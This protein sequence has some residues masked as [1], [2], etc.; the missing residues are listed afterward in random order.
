MLAVTWRPPLHFG[1]PALRY[2]LQVLRPLHGGDSAA[3]MLQELRLAEECGQQLRSWESLSDQLQALSFTLSD[4]VP[5]REYVFR[6]RAWSEF[7]WSEF[8]A[9]S[10]GF[11][12]K[13]RL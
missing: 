13:R 7:G 12:T 5:A 2:E 6:V 9:P 1:A 11:R 4:V 10:A 8:S 3:S